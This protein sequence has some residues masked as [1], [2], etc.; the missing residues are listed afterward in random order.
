MQEALRFRAVDAEAVESPDFVKRARLSRRDADALLR[1]YGVDYVLLGP[2]EVAS[3]K[4]NLQFWSQYTRLSPD[5]A[6]RVY[7][8]R[9]DQPRIHQAK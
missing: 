6:Y 7:Q 5:G 4:A 3:Y 9:I 2:A 8:T 1:Q